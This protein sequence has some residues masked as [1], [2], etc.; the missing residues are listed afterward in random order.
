MEACAVSTISIQPVLIFSMRAAGQRQGRFL[1][2]CWKLLYL[3]SNHLS[4]PNRGHLSCHKR[5]HI[6]CL[7]RRRDSCQPPA[8][9]SSV[10][11]GHMSAVETGHMPAD[12]TGQIPHTRTQDDCHTEFDCGHLCSASAMHVTLT[13]L[14]GVARKVP[15]GKASDTSMYK[16][17]HSNHS[18]LR[19]CSVLHQW[20]LLCE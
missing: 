19:P 3:N 10:E 4:F 8:V 5:K 18:P 9:V 1:Y 14:A 17:Q 7:N 13:L 2:F 12:E 16:K 20:W 15:D 11:T 6:S